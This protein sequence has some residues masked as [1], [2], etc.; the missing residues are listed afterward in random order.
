MRLIQ[1]EHEGRLR[2]A[3]V[4][5]SNASDGEGGGRVR[6]IDADQGTYGLARRAIAEGRSLSAIVEETLSATRLDYAEL[7][8]GRRLLPP[9]THPD[10]AH[11]LVS[12]T[13]LTHLGSADTR[14]AMHAKLN[15][16]EHELTDSMRM[17]KMGVDGGKP[18]EGTV[19]TQPEWFYKG[20]LL[21]T[22]PSPRD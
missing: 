7:I 10:P 1:C 22:S 14:S 15:A 12:G 4:E 18:Q 8:E 9:L 21:Y 16:D 6:L 5:E 2:A 13:G 17:F 19:G 20:C 11:C 3:L